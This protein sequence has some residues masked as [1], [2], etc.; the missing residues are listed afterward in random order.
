MIQLVILLQNRLEFKQAS[1]RIGVVF[2]YHYHRHPR[3]HNCSMQLGFDSLT[4][5][6]IILVSECLEPLADQS[7]VEVICELCAGVYAP[8]AQKNVVSTV[9]FG[10]RG[11]GLLGFPTRIH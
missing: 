1:L 6:D 8:K 3:T 11:V 9:Q 2:R 7:V 10:I 4:P 5:L